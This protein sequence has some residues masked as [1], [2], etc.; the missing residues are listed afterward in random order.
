MHRRKC[1][2]FYAR[3]SC[4]KEVSSGKL[5]GIGST[6]HLS[7]VLEARQEHSVL[8]LVVYLMLLNDDFVVT[9]TRLTAELEYIDC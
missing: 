1:F 8:L 5:L 7:R 2:H 4:A 6:V 3:F 9:N